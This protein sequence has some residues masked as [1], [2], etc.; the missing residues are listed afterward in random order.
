MTKINFNNYNNNILPACFGIDV[1]PSQTPT[2][3]RTPTKT[4][5]PTP[6]PTIT[7]TRDSTPTPTRTITSTIT[8]TPSITLTK[9][10]TKTPNQTPTQTRTPSAT[11]PICSRFQNNLVG[12]TIIS[13]TSNYSI[14]L[15]TASTPGTQGL[16]W[17]NN[18]G[19]YTDDSDFRGVVVH[20]GILLPGQTAYVRFTNLGIL[21]S[22]VG[23]T[24]NGISSLLWTGP[25]CAITVSI[26]QIISSRTPTPTLTKT[27]GITPTSTATPTKSI[28]PTNTVTPTAT[29]TRTAIPTRTVT[30]TLTVT[31]TRTI[32]CS[33][34]FPWNF[35]STVPNSFITSISASINGTKIACAN[36]FTQGTLLY[37]STNGGNSWVSSLSYTPSRGYGSVNGDKVQ[38]SQ[39]KYSN[40]SN[41]LYYVMLSTDILG[42]YG[43]T[44]AGAGIERV[45][46]GTINPGL[47]YRGTLEGDIFTTNN[48][49]ILY[50]SHNTEILVSGSQGTLRELFVSNDR[51]N[52]WIRKQKYSSDPNNS[53]GEWSYLRL[54]SVDGT[55]LFGY[56]LNDESMYYS[57]DSGTIF[58]YRGKRFD[59]LEIGGIEIIDMISSNNDLSSLIMLA[60]SRT[61]GKNQR[62]ILSSTNSGISWTLINT[63]DLP[64]ATEQSIILYYLK[65][66][67]RS[68]DGKILMALSWDKNIYASNNNGVSWVR[69]TNV[70]DP[71]LRG[72]NPDW[73]DIVPF[74]NTEFYA[75]T[76]GG[77]LF[78]AN[79]I[80]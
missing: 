53:W 12:V 63:T 69:Q 47:G 67:Y 13:S 1:L 22:F 70:L 19:G 35:I 50:F 56:T 20:A 43:T 64:I 79:A 52:S 78:K 51:G 57:S 60:R 66:L 14:G 5:T 73:K 37:T 29:P 18:S 2:P 33:L 59:D 11:P 62:Y 34:N 21:N 7:R 42:G 28:T 36:N 58:G 48:S 31:P 17:G 80:C 30:P 24:A 6:T 45:G 55:K 27:P 38:L 25:G 71:A 10:P 72:S 44:I 77:A 65:A 75:I 26:D 40:D 76:E 61:G 32:S 46:P 16:I 4:P 54:C 3:T 9:T 74:N 49:N 68:G 8:T 15:V 39:V 23:T 41:T